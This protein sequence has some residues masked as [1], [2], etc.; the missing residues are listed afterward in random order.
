MRLSV[1]PINDW[2]ADYDSSHRHATNKV[3]HWV[4]V[5][6]IVVSLIGLLWALPTPALFDGIS[7]FLNWGTFFL[8]A[9]MVYYCILS[10]KLALGMLPFALMTAMLI[11]W[12]DVI[13]VSLW[14]TSTGIF[15]FAWAGQFIGHWIEGQRP[16]FLKDL[17][18]LMIG[19]LWLVAAI[20]RR[21]KISY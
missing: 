13:S 10:I 2:L 20:Y 15:V 11:S 12:L 5:P 14:L 3:L 1:R 8:A 16:S 19:P 9:S 7:E 18:F 17:Q 21:M 6:L 4:C